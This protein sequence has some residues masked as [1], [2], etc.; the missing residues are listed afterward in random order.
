[1]G[2][3]TCRSV[4]L[5]S[6]NSDD[7]AKERVQPFVQSRSS[8]SPDVRPIVLVVSPAEAALRQLKQWFCPYQW[9]EDPKNRFVQW[10][11]SMKRLTIQKLNSIARGRGGRCL[12]KQ[13]V[14][15]RIPLYWQ[16]AFGHRWK[17]LG[18]DIK[19]RWCPDCAGIKPLTLK[20]MKDLASQRG[21]QCL[22][23]R[24][25]NART[26][27]VWRCAKGHSWPA[28]PLGVKRGVWC[29]YCSHGL[30]LSLR[31]LQAEANK[32]GGRCLSTS[33]V[34]VETHLRWK[35]A[36]GHEWSARPASIR[37]GTWCPYC[38]KVQ[39]LKLEEMQQIALERGGKCISKSY[40]NCYTNL[41]WECVRGHR[42]KALPTN[43]KG[44]SLR[45]G[46]WCRVCYELKRVFQPRGD[47]E[48]MQNLARTRGGRCLSREYVNSKTHL[49]WEC[50]KGHRWKA[51]PRTV[52]VGAWCPICARNQRLTLEEFQALAHHRGGKC[53]SD[54][55]KNR[56]TKLL[57]QC[58]AGH[59]WF[60]RPGE[61]KRGSWCNK[62]A[63]DR[64]RSPW[65]ESVEH[66]PFLEQKITALVSLI[67][68]SKIFFPVSHERTVFC[69]LTSS[70][71][72]RLLRLQSQKDSSRSFH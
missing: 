53:L 24:Y 42:W 72:R 41:V 15:F 63:I 17:A 47:I 43:V 32:R 54:G 7:F 18:S 30:P 39:K 22:S 6:S 10:L 38:A 21:G 5:T 28:T 44:S 23:K 27:L 48:K 58:K 14:D 19:R 33:Y 13:Y 65:K 57:W 2:S 9:R 67:R 46:T 20:E 36:D 59:K 64:R 51:Q 61:V 8:R 26:K 55:Y 66:G 31:D 49:E 52:S 35:C 1:M 12:S 11:G 68:F 3:S 40:T 4:R 69:A 37:K 45:K 56:K 29:P 25:V 71:L 34:N 50:E 70:G 60:A 62:C 16:C